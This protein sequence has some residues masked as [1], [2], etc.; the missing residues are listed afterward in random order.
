MVAFFIPM[1]RTNKKPPTKIVLGAP[2]PGVSNAQLNAYIKRTAEL[3]TQRRTFTLG[4]WV[5]VIAAFAMIHYAGER[6]IAADRAAELCKQ[7]IEEANYYA[8]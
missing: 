2:T 6:R 4:L 8:P 7:Q 5:F 3:R 1:N